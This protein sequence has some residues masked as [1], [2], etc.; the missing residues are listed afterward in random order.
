MGCRSTVSG[1]ASGGVSE[2]NFLRQLSSR[3]QT[4]KTTRSVM[5]AAIEG[6]IPAWKR[7]G[8]KLKYAPEA[9]ETTS[10]AQRQGEPSSA[11]N[12]LDLDHTNSKSSKKARK[13]LDG[14]QSAS[15]NTPTPPAI[16][17]PSK[18]SL[19]RKSVSFTP[20]TKTEDGDSTKDLYNTWVASQK[21]SDPSF[22]PS[23]FKQGALQ[24]ITPPT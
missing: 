16:A 19:T 4:L 18:Q 8:L 9:V 6:H 17:T 1:S 7:L 15:A 12:G 13:S 14:P 20:E 11:N 24:S 2:P 5:P 3:K 21:T 22:D 23:S 10:A